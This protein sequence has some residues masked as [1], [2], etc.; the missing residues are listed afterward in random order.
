MAFDPLV[1]LILPLAC[2][3]QEAGLAFAMVILLAVLAGAVEMMRGT[4]T[5]ALL[6]EL[7]PPLLTTWP[8]VSVIVPACNEERQLE[9]ALRSLLK[10]DYENLEIIAVDDRSTDQTG[11]ILDRL[12]KEFPRLMVLHITALPAGW[13]GKNHAL[14][15]GARRASGEWLLFTD[16]D[17]V[18][19]P[20]SLRRAVGYALEKRVD[21]LAIAP[22]IHMKG[23]LL[24]LAASAFAVFFG[25][26]AR[27]WKARDP[28][29]PF[30]IGIGAFNLV[31]R[32]AYQAIGTHQA[33]AL[34]PVDD[35]KLGKLIK[36]RG[37][38][39]DVVVGRD[40]LT[41]EWYASF[42]E[43][44]T[45]LEKNSYAGVEYRLSLL[46]AGTVAILLVNV[47]P[48]LA[49]FLT[50][51]W[52]LAIYAVVAALTIFCGWDQARFLGFNPRFAWFLP[53]STLLFLYV[54]WS[55]TLKTIREGSITWRGTR[56]P[57]DELRKHNV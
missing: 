42:R 20:T 5:L 32:E 23:T 6:K 33:I 19:E 54:L 36:R 3:V 27:P 31:R 13:L 15:E 50:T 51:G 48:F 37:F 40:M 38:R 28:R 10:Q 9:A 2:T 1:S 45:G 34:S 55:C 57:L 4:R 14:Q 52:T 35:M 25:F 22:S 44:R 43:L 46:A 24:N 16:A 26:Y 41:I 8:R 39:Q 47:W 49:L 53:A 7:P 29:S 30:H 17:V 11:V 56:Y 21:H 18:M 12:A